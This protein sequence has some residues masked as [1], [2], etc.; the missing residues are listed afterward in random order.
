MSD[1]AQGLSNLDADQQATVTP[2]AHPRT[3]TVV[4]GAAITFLGTVGFMLIFWN[5]FLGMRSGDGGFTSGV[6]LLN[7]ILP[8]RDYYGAVPPLFIARCALILGIFGE[9]PITLRAAGVL[10]RGLLSLLLYSWLV[11]FF[12]VKDA[13]L[14]ALVT[15]VVSSG[16]YADPVS[17]YNHFT[18]LLAIAAGFVASYALDRDRST[19]ALISIG[20]LSGTLAM[21]SF[22]SKQTIGLGMILAI[23][24]AVGLVLARLGS[25]AKAFRFVGGFA[26]GCSASASVVAG[27]MLHYGLL[28]A[29]FTQTFVQGPAAKAS[30]PADFVV[31]T[32]VVL[33]D[34]Y[35]WAALLA[36]QFCCFGG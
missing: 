1:P 33:R 17:S 15:V 22:A 14:A 12:R 23:P 31:H 34:Q 26:V 4:A 21:L 29:F 24:L 27:W 16:D 30:R 25:I 20:L 28:R 11:R 13:A 10:E 2:A 6:F 18:V 36:C 7:G 5:R 3:L 35:W 8:Y 32:F 9:L 19:R